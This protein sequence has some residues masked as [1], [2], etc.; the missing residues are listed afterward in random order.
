MQTQ[1]NG[2]TAHQALDELERCYDAAVEALRNAIRDFTEQG[3]L[4]DAE[5]R[6]QGLFV[7]PELRLT[8]QGEGPQQNRTRAW[9]RFTHTGRYS[10]TITRLRCCATIS[11]SSCR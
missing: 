8:W 5:Q 6:Q 3:T 7:Y 10:T 1:R 2:L 4:P 9:G 11:A